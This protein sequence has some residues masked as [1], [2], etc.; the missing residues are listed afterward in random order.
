MAARELL[1]S[2]WF[3]ARFGCCVQV[4]HDHVAEVTVVCQRAHSIHLCLL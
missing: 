1:R 4:V 2:A 3:M